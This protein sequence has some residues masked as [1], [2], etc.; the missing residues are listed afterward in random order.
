[1]AKHAEKQMDPVKSGPLRYGFHQLAEAIKGIGQLIRHPKMLI[2]TLILAVL[3]P[4]LAFLKG[5][6]SDSIIFGAASFLTFAQGGLYGGFVGA[7]G[8]ILGKSFFAWFITMTLMPLLTGVKPVKVKRTSL[9]KSKAEPGFSLFILGWG[10]ALIAYNFMSGDAR[11]ENSIV[12]ITAL[13][14][15]RRMLKRERGGMIDFVRAFTRGRWSQNPPRSLAKGMAFGFF[16]GVITSFIV[17]GFFCYMAG[18]IL[19]LTGLVLLML[20]RGRRDRARLAVAVLMAS[21][22]LPFLG[23]Q[24]TALA[25]DY[26]N[27][28]EAYG[29]EQGEPLSNM[30][31]VN[32]MQ[33]SPPASMQLTLVAA[34]DNDFSSSAALAGAQTVDAENGV[35]GVFSVSSPQLE[36]YLFNSSIQLHLE[37]DGWYADASTSYEA[38][39]G[40]TEYKTVSGSE[41]TDMKCYFI[42]T[43]GAIDSY[44]YELYSNPGSAYIS[45]PVPFAYSQMG[46]EDNSWSSGTQILA[47]VDGVDREMSQTPG[48]QT[49]NGAWQLIET[50]T[51]RLVLTD[52]GTGTMV[53]E[54]IESVAGVDDG[55]DLNLVEVDGYRI[56]YRSNFSGSIEYNAEFEAPPQQLGAE[57]QLSVGITENNTVDGMSIGPVSGAL[58]LAG[59]RPQ[60][61]S[62]GENNSNELGVDLPYF[63]LERQGDVLTIM[64]PQGADGER[65]TLEMVMG[66]TALGAVILA[67]VYE[68][69][70]DLAAVPAVDQAVDE[71][72]TEDGLQPYPPE[73][74]QDWQDEY[75]EGWDDP[76]SEWIQG[77]NDGLDDWTPGIDGVW[78]AGIGTIWGEPADDM[79]TVVINGVAV[80]GGII[81]AGAAA[82][83]LGGS[84]GAGQGT[85][86]SGSPDGTGTRGDIPNSPD[87]TYDPSDDTVVVKSPNG[88]RELYRRNPKTGQFEDSRGNQIDLGDVDRAN[89]DLQRDLDASRRE[90]ERMEKGEDGDS[91]YWNKVNRLQHLKQR[92]EQEAD[93]DSDTIENRMIR[94]I[95][96]MQ[97][98]I[99]SGDGL[100]QAGYE[101][102]RNTYG[103]LK[104]GRIADERSLPGEYT[105]WQQVKDAI[106]MSG[107][108]LARGE[109]GK[110]MAVRVLAGIVTAGKSEFGFEAAKSVYTVKDYVNAGG[111]SWREAVSIAA[112]NTIIDE[113]IGRVVEGGIG[114]IGKAG[115]LA[116]D[117]AKKTNLGRRI[118]DGVGGIVDRTGQFLGTN[119]RDLLSKTLKQGAKEADQG[120][121]AI[122]AGAGQLDDWAKS[123]AKKADD[124]LEGSLGKAAKQADGPAIKTDTPTVK[125][126]DTP[127][128]STVKSGTGSEPASTK[129]SDSRKPADAGGQKDAET[130]AKT[131]DAD[132]TSQS[133]G[134][135]SDA[136]A[137]ENGS[138]PAEKKALT[139][140]SQ[141]YKEASAKVD[142]ME[143]D[144]R[145]AAQKKIDEF[146]AANRQK[147]PRDEAFEM[148]QKE[149]DKK[150]SDLKKSQEQLERNPNSAQAKD[151]YDEAVRNVQQ[152][153][154]AVQKIN[155]TPDEVGKDT[156]AGFNRRNQQYNKATLENTQARLAQ[157]RGLDP[158]QV[159]FV[160][161]TNSGAGMREADASRTARPVDVSGRTAPDTPGAKGPDDI[162]IPQVKDSSAPRDQDV[163]GR[164]YDEKTKQWIDLPEED[165]ARVYKEELYKIHH[166]G[167]LPKIEVDGKQVVDEDAVKSFAEKMD[168]TVTDRTGKDAYGRGDK[169]LVNIL[170]KDSAE[171][172][173]FDDI[174]SVT[175]TMEYKTNEWF[176]RAEAMERRAAQSGDL[177]PGNPMLQQA[178]SMKMEGVRQLTKQFNNQVT[179]Q[180]KAAAAA[181]Q[182]VKVPERLFASIKVLDEV[183]KP[184]GL[185]VSQAEQI[186]KDMGT[187][188]D[189]VVKQSSSLMESIARFNK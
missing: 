143:A 70:S 188:V 103:K 19:S 84:L 57:S 4:A 69:D 66:T 8:G 118:V 25:A 158:N 168:H 97:K 55:Q 180:V 185:T 115:S 179:N 78:P 33:A 89:R 47:R 165:V 96:K 14:S 146:K 141:E 116:G 124:A 171:I 41:A 163:T 22:F 148:G 136:P 123:A 152:D 119:V 30:N 172:K 86:G 126:G 44:L 151:D 104:T 108:E 93:G 68:W 95:E 128:S 21:L 87:I 32:A 184:G 54:P 13:L 6:F 74:A 94:Q 127:D 90:R 145:E 121:K 18:A 140:E 112:T 161:A 186:L 162:D 39:N 72:S 105:D 24:N 10:A 9:K 67:N 135:Q 37:A 71:G 52:Y 133:A 81:G 11:L 113:G 5:Q 23:M 88:S 183:G 34:G 16:I 189:D 31:L 120:A 62:S 98:A 107:E 109:S 110:A 181:G 79:E 20:G 85:N 51:Y 48:G 114:L 65:A 106:G 91:Q 117:L 139:K 42:I 156:I 125:N 138:G 170:N 63:Y 182:A 35:S 73:D 75:E 99:D 130:N 12:G 157:E 142:R 169:D 144:A 61:F 58:W 164:M 29:I 101:R 166:K 131:N 100:D 59:E 149:A 60:T 28:Y 82:A 178:E 175:G 46:L 134:K 154:F 2:P 56:R 83:G 173:K 159:K 40:F 7:L 53:T 150:L 64:V 45:I 129:P 80:I 153:K 50:K 15:C 49:A 92:L 3:W 27:P 43:E 26:Q 17:Q 76:F 137:K 122:K 177:S 167:E 176:E 160:E 187:S 132:D 155:D 111:D 1:M 102:I 77:V 174:T 36:E 38:N 147:T